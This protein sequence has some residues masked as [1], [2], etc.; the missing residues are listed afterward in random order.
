VIAPFSVGA[1]G[2]PLVGPSPSRQLERPPRAT[3]SGRATGA[4]AHDELAARQRAIAPCLGGRSARPICQA[5]GRST[6]RFH[7]WWRRH[8]GAGAEGPYGLTRATHRAAQRIAPEVERAARYRLVGASA[9]P[10]ELKALAIRPL[11][12]SD[13]VLGRSPCYL[14]DQ[15]SVRS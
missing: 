6:F 14:S 12:R 15:P 10:A 5:L 9:I 13:A 8:L 1:A 11:R 4:P 7:N 3:A 2:L